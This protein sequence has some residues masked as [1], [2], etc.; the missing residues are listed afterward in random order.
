MP[1]QLVFATNNRHKL[2]EVSAKIGDQFQLLTLSDIGCTADIEE[3]GV[4]F[5]ENA[6]IKS[7]FIYDT[8]G[9]DCFGDDSGLE[10]D[11]LNGA[12]GV[13]SARYS[14]VH[15]DHAANIAKVLQNMEGVTD[16]K[17]RFRTVISLVMNGMEYFYAGSVEGTIRTEISGDGGFGYDPIF[18]PDGYDITFAE[19]SMEEKNAISHR[20]RAMEMLIEFLKGLQVI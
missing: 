5:A 14:G 7:R 2:D 19:M 17:A 11:A 3:T 9:M 4:T 13:Y 18:Q 8:Y 20:G 16:R 12:P 10:I 6:S 15:G 1:R